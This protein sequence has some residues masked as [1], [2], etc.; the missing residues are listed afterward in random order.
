MFF[1]RRRELLSRAR[2]DAASNRRC[3]TCRSQPAVLNGTGHFVLMQSRF[4]IWRLVETSRAW[5]S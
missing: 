5:I 3:P 4:G 1:L 2:L